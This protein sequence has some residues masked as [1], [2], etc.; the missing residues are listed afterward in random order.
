[1]IGLNMVL[2]V[3][4][5][6]GIERIVCWEDA[7]L[8]QPHA[9]RPWHE[10]TMKCR[11]YRVSCKKWTINTPLSVTNQ[12][13]IDCRG[14]TYSSTGRLSSRISI[15]DKGLECYECFKYQGMLKTTHYSDR[16]DASD[17]FCVRAFYTTFKMKW[18]LSAI[19]IT[20]TKACLV[21][22]DFC[23]R[24]SNGYE[25]GRNEASWRM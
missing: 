5:K 25:R 9:G 23:I 12:S 13:R 14:W 20:V 2:V 24:G 15:D 19:Y 11:S 7:Q 21:F 17:L 18:V 3:H 6:T 22:K 16:F 8:N 4:V 10:Q 1:M